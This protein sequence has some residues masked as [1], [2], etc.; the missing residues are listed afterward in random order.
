MAIEPTPDLT[1]AARAGCDVAWP[2]GADH[3]CIFP[4]CRG[5]REGT[6]FLAALAELA[7]PSAEMLAATDNPRSAEVYW[8]AMMGAV[9]GDDNAA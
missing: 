7:E 4:M 2:Y 6:F 1:R 8:R 3:P 9:L 5:C